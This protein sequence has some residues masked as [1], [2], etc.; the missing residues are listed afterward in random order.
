MRGGDFSDGDLARFAEMYSE[1]DYPA[2]QKLREQ[3]RDYPASQ[4]HGTK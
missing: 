3:V 4:T 2:S 1:K